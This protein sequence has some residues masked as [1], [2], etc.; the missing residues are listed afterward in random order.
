MTDAD[1]MVAHG[2]G[3]ESAIEATG[4][5][6]APGHEEALADLAAE[7]ERLRAGMRVLAELCGD[8]TDECPLSTRGCQSDCVC[9][10]LP[11]QEAIVQPVT[12]WCKW[13]MEEAEAQK[14]GDAQ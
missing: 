13:A 5:T 1:R 7:N 6:A 2:M 14:A 10:R 4:S 3:Y 9:G 11:V 12:C 8:L